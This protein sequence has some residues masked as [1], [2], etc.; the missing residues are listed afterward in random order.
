[1]YKRQDYVF[2][3]PSL[4]D[5]ATEDDG[6]LEFYGDD[7][8]DGYDGEKT[9]TF[10]LSATGDSNYATCSRCVSV[11]QDEGDK[12]FFQ[13]SGTMVVDASSDQLDGHP[14]GKLTDVTLIEVTIDSST[15][16]STPVVGGACLHI[17]SAD[18]TI[19]APVVPAG[20]LCDP[21]YYGDGS[22]DCGCGVADSD[23]ADATV[24]SCDYCNDDGS[25]S[26]N[27]ADCPSNI[28]PTNNAVCQ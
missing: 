5:A 27:A 9:G 8:T 12:I 6:I 17:T 21:D 19:A 14:S 2:T 26:A 4:G 13:K 11:Y 15:F 20:W 3:V 16:T 23:C 1:M 25:C 24:G 18:F 7:P 22:C 28:N 10:D